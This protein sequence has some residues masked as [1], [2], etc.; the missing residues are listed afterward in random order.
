MI[1]FGKTL[2][3][4]RE[5][6]GYTTQELAS[7]T[8]MLNTTIVELENEDFS[9]IPA[10]IYGRG[11]VKLYCEAVGLDPKPMIAEFMDILNGNRIVDVRERPVTPPP[12]APAET[13]REVARETAPEPVPPEPEPSTEIPATPPVDTPIPATTVTPPPVHAAYQDD[14]FSPRPGSNAVPV[15]LQPPASPTETESGGPAS[16]PPTQTISR[17]AAPIRQM[18]VPSLPPTFWRLTL[19]ATVALALLVLAVFGLRAPHGALSGSADEQATDNVP[20][21]EASPEATEPVP[22]KSETAAPTKAA[23]PRTP[24]KIPSLYMD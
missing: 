2:R 14:F 22:A 19:V 10:P 17:Y 24:Q 15:T 3:A 23:A 13:E 16:E 6:K 8:R 1:E 5:A 7:M 20:A 11:F 18:K 12:P 4:A 21:V 9:R